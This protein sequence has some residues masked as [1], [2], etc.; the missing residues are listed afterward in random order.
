MIG[1]LLAAL[2]M[3]DPLYRWVYSYPTGSVP[4][5]EARVSG[6]RAAK[7][8]AQKRRNQRKARRANHA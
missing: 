2:G 7:R 1:A 5:R 6:V 8:Q 3:S 4:L